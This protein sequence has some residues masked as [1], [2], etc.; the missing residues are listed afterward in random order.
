M[1]NTY[2][3]EPE[4]KDDF[5][6]EQFSLQ[7]KRKALV[8]TSAGIACLIMT[9]SAY[10]I[11]MEEQDPIT[12]ETQKQVV[13]K[14]KSNI[15]EHP[16]NDSEQVAST[17]PSSQSSSS[18][19]NS[20]ETLDISNDHNDDQN[21]T[22]PSSSPSPNNNPTSPDQED[23][24]LSDIV[25]IADP[26]EESPVYE[27]G[28]PPPSNDQTPEQKPPKFEWN[29]PGFLDNL[30]PCKPKS[31]KETSTKEKPTATD[32][33]WIHLKPR[34]Q[35]DKHS[36]L[37]KHDK[38]DK[39]NKHNKHDKRDKQTDFKKENPYQD[40]KKIEKHLRT[41]NKDKHSHFIKKNKH[42]K[43]DPVLLKQQRSHKKSS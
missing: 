34:H 16:V 27:K 13:S 15:S 25:A 22:T 31:S 37:K 35:D 41:Q 9:F 5:S 29:Q 36:D 10:V 11:G 39:H 43:E 12:L 1:K 19:E 24:D 3:G 14:K 40:F 8:F 7:V 17:D 32:Q 33:H 28:D 4:H 38:P 20:G 26:E 42:L 30:I 18:T 2:R 6:I 21:Q 23:H